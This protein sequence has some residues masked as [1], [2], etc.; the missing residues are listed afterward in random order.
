VRIAYLGAVLA[1]ALVSVAGCGSSIPSAPEPTS[2]IQA[3]V[4]RQAKEAAA[5]E[6]AERD[7]EAKAG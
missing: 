5:A 4:E 1:A 2:E 6:K 7:A 3:D